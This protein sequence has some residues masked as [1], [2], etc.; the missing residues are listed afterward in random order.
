[1]KIK[2]PDSISNE[3]LNPIALAYFREGG[4]MDDLP[5]VIGIS[6]RRVADYLEWLKD[7]AAP[8]SQTGD[9]RS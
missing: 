4:E 8:G 2:V 6:E 3:D 5:A 9:T 1:M 7:R